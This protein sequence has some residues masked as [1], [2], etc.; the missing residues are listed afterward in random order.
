M[1][2]PSFLL[3]QLFFWDS[4]IIW[5]WWSYYSLE[6]PGNFGYHKQ[7]WIQHKKPLSYKTFPALNSES[8]YLLLE[9]LLRKTLLGMWSAIGYLILVKVLEVALLHV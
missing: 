4:H 2:A 6:N 7:E 3:I 9:R 1:A 8:W 5:F